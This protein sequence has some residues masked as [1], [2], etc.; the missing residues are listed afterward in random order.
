MVTVVDK[1][2]KVLEISKKVDKAFKNNKN[3]DL[4][5]FKGKLKLTDNPVEFQRKLRDEWN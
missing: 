1:K 5:K 4:S 3:K 2:I